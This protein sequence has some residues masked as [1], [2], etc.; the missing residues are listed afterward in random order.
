MPTFHL[1]G[2]FGLAVSALIV[3]FILAVL[4]GLYA[5]GNRKRPR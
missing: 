4:L 5:Y 1:Y 2:A 3:A